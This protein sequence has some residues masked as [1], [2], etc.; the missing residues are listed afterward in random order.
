LNSNQLIASLC[1]Q[2]IIET[3]SKMGQTHMMD[4]VRRVNSTYSQVN[5]NIEILEWEGIV[6][7]KKLGRMKM[8]QLRREDEKTKAILK[9]LEI[10]KQQQLLEDLYPLQERVTSFASG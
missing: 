1:R 8:I 5:R 4:L 3:L 6:V 10:L 2:K 9:A 7:T